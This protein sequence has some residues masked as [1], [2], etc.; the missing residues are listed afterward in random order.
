VTIRKHEDFSRY[1]IWCYVYPPVVRNKCGLHDAAELHI[2]DETDTSVEEDI[3]L[4]LI[5]ANPDLCLT[6]RDTMSDEDNSSPSS[7][8]DTMSVS[9][10]ND[11]TSRIERG[12]PIGR[13]ASSP[14]VRNQSTT[15]V[16]APEASKQEHFYDGEKGT[17]YLAWRLK[18][19]SRK[20]NWR[21]VKEATATL[22]Q[23][24]KR[25][26]SAATMPQQFEGDACREAISFLVHSSD[27]AVVFQKMKM[28]FQHRQDL[29]HDLQRTTDIFKT[30]LRFLDVKGLVNQDFLLL[31]GAETSSKMLEKWDTAFKP[32]VI[33]EAKHLT[34]STELRRLLKAAE[35]PGETDNDT[36]ILATLRDIIGLSN[37]HRRTEA[38]A[39]SAIIDK[40]F[41]VHLII[42]EDVFRTTKFM[43]DQLQSATFDLEAADDLAQSVTI[44]ISD[45]HI[46]DTSR[47]LSEL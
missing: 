46:S 27:E 26:R 45:M 17:G 25:Q 41:V 14:A 1:L 6:I 21:P 34:P 9:S 35:K 22:A 7:L 31:F 13:L 24:P 19:M 42:F 3:L 8:T 20:T 4:E 32:K 23:G 11:I 5:E 29:V 37:L 2:F 16:S 30:F 38:R 36:T 40:T 28:T 18:T 15:V 47:D 12:I 33:E 39:L 44:A 43:S 10:D